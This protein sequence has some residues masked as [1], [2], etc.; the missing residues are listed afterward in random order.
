[1][2]LSAISEGI[3]RLWSAHISTGNIIEKAEA[4]GDF[5]P[6]KRQCKVVEDL[7]KQI[8]TTT[9]K[10]L[11]GA[12]P[13]LRMNINHGIRVLTTGILG[14]NETLF[15][16]LGDGG[17][18]EVI[19]LAHSHI[20]TLL[21]RLGKIEYYIDETE[22]IDLEQLEKIFSNFQKPFEPLKI[23]GEIYFQPGKAN[24]DT[25][26]E[27]FEALSDLQVACGGYGLQFLDQN[28]EVFA[29]KGALV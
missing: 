18:P 1:M 21:A 10:A 19:R 13:D 28:E 23:T 3:K 15:S 25:I 14:W 8:E 9:R 29:F 12:E 22:T 2:D 27:V 16:G 24:T 17:D 20:T 11:E 7:A 4:K 26:R 6:I 5:E